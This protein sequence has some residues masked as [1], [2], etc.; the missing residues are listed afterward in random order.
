ML[1]A[2]TVICE[3]NVF[4]CLLFK[5]QE[6]HIK[7]NISPNYRQGCVDKSYLLSV[8]KRRY[9]VGFEK[10]RIPCHIPTK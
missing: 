6:L 3:I 5:L 7:A 1:L 9:G 10:P 2:N 8:I 4:I